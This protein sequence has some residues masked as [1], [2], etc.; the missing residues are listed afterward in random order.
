[1]AEAITLSNQIAPE[2]LE[3]SVEDPK[4]MLDDIKHAGAIFID[5][6]HIC[7]IPCFGSFGQAVSEEKV[8]KKSTN[9]KQVLPVAAM[10][11]SESGQNDNS[12]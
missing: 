3:L 7:F 2:H 6:V 8:Y 10:F 5:K 12:L 9:Q 4:S 11:V 1:M